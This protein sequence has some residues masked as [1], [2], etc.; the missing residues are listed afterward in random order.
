MGRKELSEICLMVVEDAH[1]AVSGSHPLSELIR[2]CLLQRAEFRILAYT[3]CKLDKVGQL[4]SIVMNLQVDLIRSLSSI[5]EEVSLTF[6]SP[7]MCKLYI[8]ISEDIRRIG[9]ELLK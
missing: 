4:Q 1:R 7:R 9:N 8:S 5:R 3:D 2:T 6:A